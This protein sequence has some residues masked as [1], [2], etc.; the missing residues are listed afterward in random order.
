M[1]AVAEDRISRNLPKLPAKL[2]RVLWARLYY[3][4]I[5]MAF[6]KEE[7]AQRRAALPALP[8]GFSLIVPTTEEHYAAWLDLLNAEPAFGR[9]SR[10][11]L[12]S[13]LLSQLVAPGAAS[14]MLHDGEVIGCS[15]AV[16][17][18]TR[19]KR[20]ALGTYLYVKPKYRARTSIAYV[21]TV[22][23]FGHGVAAGYDHIWTHAPTHRL[24]ALAIHL[25]LGCRPVYRTLSSFF[26]WRKVLKRL[27]PVVAKLKRKHDRLAGSE[28]L[29]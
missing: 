24:S 1:S 14:L 11:R 25:S 9:W 15:C 27:N 7:I 19:R 2:A 8:E 3:N 26:Q 23:A 29:S 6:P 18:S 20:I 22:M 16:D 10:E 13:E 5:T 28:Q 21:L 17:G 12:Q 4:Q